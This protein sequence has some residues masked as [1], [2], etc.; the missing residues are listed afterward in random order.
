MSKK[1]N[2]NNNE[3]RNR[4]K[5]SDTYPA[6]DPLV[7]IC[8]P[9]ESQL[10]Y[11]KKQREAGFEVVLW[12]GIRQKAL[13][14]WYEMKQRAEEFKYIDMPNGSI[15]ANAFKIDR[16]SKRIEDRLACYSAAAVSERNQLNRKGSLAKRR[17]HEN[18]IC[19]V[20]IL[21]NDIISIEHWESNLSP[22]EKRLNEAKEEV[23]NWRKKHDNLEKEKETLFDEIISELLANHNDEQ[24]KLKEL[25]KEN[26][27]LVNYI[28]RGENEILRILPRGAGIPELK[29]RQA[30]NRKLKQLKTSAQKALEF[31]KIF[32]LDLHFLKLKDPGSSQTFTVDFMDT[33]QSEVEPD[34]QNSKYESL[35]KEDK[36]TVES[37]LF[38]MDKFGVSDEF[39]HELSMAIDWG[40]PS[41]ILPN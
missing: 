2:N 33:T 28:E 14:K 5:M 15:P 6:S 9:P 16:E 3:N 1:H 39:V 25:Q 13:I 36:T 26:D 38:L 10:N 23:C 21:K 12:L 29:S 7:N 11:I 4:K 34:P 8:D 40:F 20:A 30:Q 24:E 17:E 37:I 41:Q 18:S 19:K 27:Q 22:L 32:G 35:S 31:V